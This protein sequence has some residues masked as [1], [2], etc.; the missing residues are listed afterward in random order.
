[1]NHA[2]M[3]H[4]SMNRACFQRIGGVRC[5]DQMFHARWRSRLDVFAA[6][7]FLIFSTAAFGAGTRP[8][9]IEE[10]SDRA[11]RAGLIATFRDA[12]GNQCRRIDERIAFDWGIG[13]PDPRIDRVFRVHWDGYLLAQLPGKHR[14]HLRVTGKAQ[15]RLGNQVVLD[16]ADDGPEQ[17]YSTSPIELTFGWHPLELTFE[18]TSKVAG[19]Q[20]FWNGPGFGLEPVSPRFLFHDSE[21]TFSDQFER[22]RQLVSALR[23]AACHQI[24]GARSAS[25]APDLARLKGN[26]HHDWLVDWLV[27]HPP[28]RQAADRPTK[29]ARRMP[30]FAMDRGAGEDLAAYLVSVAP[31]PHDSEPAKGEQASG[32]RLFLSLGCLACHRWKTLGQESLFDGGDLSEIARKRPARFFARWLADPAGLNRRHRMPIFELTNQERA[33]LAVFLS[34]LKS[35]PVSPNVPEVTEEQVVRGK[36][37]FQRQR[38]G[39]CHIAGGQ[40]EGGPRPLVSTLS[41]KSVWERSC[42]GKPSEDGMR[43]GYQLAPADQQAVQLYVSQLLPRETPFISGSEL[44]VEHNCLACHARGVALG[45]AAQLPAIAERHRELAS[46]IPAM[47]PPSLSS[48]GDKLVDAALLAAIVQKSGNRR[49]WLAVRMPRFPLDPTAAGAIQQ[50]L[51]EADRVPDQTPHQA[52]VRPAISPQALALAGPRLVTQDGFGCTSCHQVGKVVPPSAPLNARGPDLTQLSQR[53]RRTWFDRFVP[54]PTRI[55]PRME[56]PSVRVAVRGVLQDRVD[57]QLSAVWQAL[58]RP[59]FQPPQPNPVRVLRRSGIVQDQ[60]PPVFLTDVLQVDG[61]QMIKPFAIGLSNRHNLLFDLEQAQLSGWR[62]GDVARQ[63]TKG[64]TWFWEAAGLEVLSPRITGTDLALSRQG[65]AWQ[66]TANGQF[67]SELDSVKYLADGI[68]FRYR[69]RFVSENPAEPAM[70]RITQRIT[71]RENTRSVENEQS[72]V[73]SGWSGFRRAVEIQGCHPGDQLVLQVLATDA[74]TPLVLATE[75]REIR[76]S[77]GMTRLRAARSFEATGTLAAI[78]DGQGIARFTVDYQTSLPVD[79]F[80]GLPQ[81][82]TAIEPVNLQVVPGFRATRLPL[83]Q[84][85]MPTGL[86]WRPNGTLIVTS[87]KGRVWSGTDTDGDGLE[88][89]LRSLGGEWAAPFGVSATDEFVDVINKW[90]LVRLFDKDQDGVV[91]EVETLASGWG[92]TADYHDWT[93]GL[94]KD[95][96]G[97]YFVATSC[98]QDERSAAAA[99]W[100]GMVLKLEPR[101]AT[102]DHPHQFQV[103]PVTGGHRF[104]IGIAQDR[105]GDIFV[106]DNQGNYNPFNELNHVISG[107]RYGFINRIE[108]KPDFQPPLTPPAIDIPH[109]WTRSV[110]GICFLDSSQVKGVSGHASFGPF[111]GHLVGCEYD[112]RRLIRMSLQRVGDTIQGAAYPFTFAAPPVGE[113]L[114]GPLTCAVSPQGDLYVGCIRDSGWGGANNIGTL[115]RL[116]LEPDKLPVGIAE[117][118][119]IRGGFEIAF[120]GSIDRELAADKEHYAI[121]SFTRISTPTYGGPDRQRRNELIQSIQV[122]PTGRRVRLQLSELREGFVY[123]FHLQKLVSREQLFFPDE[124]YYTLRKAAR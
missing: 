28:G 87:L 47:A 84:D 4:A 67:L 46:L 13:V 1:M 36:E 26:I 108:R 23:C 55:V 34:T 100:R 42:V 79:Q 49:P 66:A 90:G 31:A 37:R 43:P 25:P 21:Q 110:N 81:K 32:Q 97:N 78:A 109:P 124:A 20:L 44:L 112:T 70:L 75:G 54:N 99:H 118:R 59:G 117:V 17:W 8:D 91:E 98:Q 50:H 41:T 14:L 94:V 89:H 10:E 123:E 16:A 19:I 33:H 72:L 95:R 111:E 38:C 12:A 114:L 85:L 9:E 65:K 103:L 74:E 106:T 48:V 56:M 121:S 62:R 7:V 119:A 40:A 30:S 92:H 122:D 104:P 116:R 2:S 27:T 102:S 86:A 53:I 120:T 29:L 24:P 107:A 73:E 69:L 51:I 113:P 64:K 88:D 45:L 18:K 101:A 15:L 93:V 83:N 22:G 11:H 96:H 82:Q 105:S 58:N 71:T 80:P 52:E 3:N 39:A 68:E 60:Q 77:D 57:R 6:S 63:R 76:L 5:W 115:V 35:K 61:R